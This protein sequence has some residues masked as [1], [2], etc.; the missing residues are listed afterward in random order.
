[1]ANLS[2]ET[3]ALG[4]RTVAIDR[5]AKRNALDRA[6]LEEL[7]DALESA[8]RDAAVRVI[9]LRGAGSKAFSAGADLEELL[10]HRT[11]DERRRHVDG[12]ARAITAMHRAPQPVI[13]RVQGYALA[14]GCG[15]AVAADFTLAAESAVFGLPEIAVGLLPMVVSAPILRATGS[16]KVVLDL[17]LTGR[18]VGA[19]EAHSLGLAT[20][21]VPDARLD[22][23]VSELAR[24]LAS[25]SPM[26][27][28]LGKEAVYAMSEMEYDVA[29]RYLREMIVLVATTEDAQEGMRA[30]F[31]GRP[32]RW[33]GR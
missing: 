14:G 5:E 13:A 8:A 32:P 27:L 9:V 17:L 20:R 22:D 6:T 24:R 28:R 30:F 25:L 18:R 15:L 1:L 29:L 16:R 4:V 33:S 2:I 7:V 31:D 23:E 26:A 19:V 10:A 12:V 11:I 3:D 21:V